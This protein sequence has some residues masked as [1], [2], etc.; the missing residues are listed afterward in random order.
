MSD[1]IV[2][3]LKP[4]REASW[5]ALGLHCNCTTPNT[6]ECGEYNRNLW[7]CPCPCHVLADARARAIIMG[8]IRAKD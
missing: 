1:E 8:V 3:S 7:A 5:K 2:V 4:L 6:M